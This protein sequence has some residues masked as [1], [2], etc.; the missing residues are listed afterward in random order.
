[1]AGNKNTCLKWHLKAKK[2]WHRGGPFRGVAK[3]IQHASQIFLGCFIGCESNVDPSVQFVHNGLG[4]VIHDT[5]SVGPRTIICQQVTL[6]VPYPAGG[7][8]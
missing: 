6:G 2:L 5:A 8:R 7:H 3:F 1:M 4:V